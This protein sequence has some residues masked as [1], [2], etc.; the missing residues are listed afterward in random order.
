MAFF[1]EWVKQGIALCEDLFCDMSS[2][3]PHRKQWEAF[4]NK[5]GLVVNKK[6]ERYYNSGFLGW[7]KSDSVFINEWCQCFN[8]L[9]SEGGDLKMFREF[10]FTYPVS[11][12]NQD[13][14]N[15]AA[16]FTN[17]P[18]STVG[19]FAMGF[20]RGRYL[21]SHPIVLKPWR[22]KFFI[23]FLKGKPPR[24]EDTAFWRNVNGSELMPFNSFKVKYK[25]GLI[26]MLRLFGRFYSKND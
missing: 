16:M 11:S 20:Q 21:M 14:L 6:L 17:Q 18:L 4:A 5:S 15:L 10:G 12:A 23:E 8:V 13:S 7:S 9:A 22:R 1:G 19:P 3:H 26:K 24:I 25:L 2:N